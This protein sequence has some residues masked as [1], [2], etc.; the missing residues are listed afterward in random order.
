MTPPGPS[1]PYVS[2][3]GNSDSSLPSM[4]GASGEEVVRSHRP[5]ATRMLIGR[6]L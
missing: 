3:C 5:A 1:H 4:P 2:V 6:L